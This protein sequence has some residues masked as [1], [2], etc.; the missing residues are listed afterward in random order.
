MRST[1]CRNTDHPRSRGVYPDEI[2]ALCG[3]CGSS[4][5]ARGLRRLRRRLAPDP[6]I[7]PARAGFTPGRSTASTSSTGSSPL[8]RGLPVRGGLVGRSAGIIP[9]RAGFT[10]AISGVCAQPMDHPRSRGVYDRVVDVDVRPVGSSPLARGLRPSRGG[11]RH[12]PG[13]I[14]ARAGFTLGQPRLPVDHQD[15]PRSRGV[16]HAHHARL[17]VDHGSSPL[18]RGLR[19][20]RQPGGSAGRII[21]A[22]AGFTGHLGWELIPLLGSSPLARGLHPAAQQ[23]GDPAGI[24]PARAGF[25]QHAP[26]RGLIRADHPRSRGVYR[27]RTWRSSCAAG[28]SPL[29]RGLPHRLPADVFR[30][31]IIPARAGFTQRDG[32]RGRLGGDH[33]RSRGVYAPLPGEHE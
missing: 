15:H 3:E 27:G 22:R 11:P 17:P 20:L 29:A 5:L 6:W 9:A 25:T 21:P 4:P 1:G 18:A 8:A 7:I 16:Y 24:I 19:V 30:A 26:A 31:R 10:T 12:P 2:S 14:P 13:I 28:S 23:A 33:P 32:D